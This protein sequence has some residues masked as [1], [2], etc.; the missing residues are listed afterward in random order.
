MYIVCTC[1][2]HTTTYNVHVHVRVHVHVHTVH[3]YT[4]YIA[5]LSISVDS[6]V[7][8]H[9]AP[10]ILPQDH[11]VRGSRINAQQD[12]APWTICCLCLSQVVTSTATLYNVH[13]AHHCNTLHVY[14]YMYMCMSVFDSPFTCIVMFSASQ[15]GMLMRALL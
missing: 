2:V 5:N 11:R 9:T 6:V 10:G 1:T 7:T 14:M 15:I 8:C 13:N 4:L 3:V 12:T